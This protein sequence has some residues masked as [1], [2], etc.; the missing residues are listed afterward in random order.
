MFKTQDINVLSFTPLIT[1]RELKERFPIS[2][3]AAETV[4]ASREAVRRIL[5]KEDRRMLAVVGPCSIHDAD[6]A[7]D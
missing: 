1:P 4:H 2:D 5:R 7:L 6:A 3:R